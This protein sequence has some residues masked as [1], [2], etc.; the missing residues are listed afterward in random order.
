MRN[1]AYLVLLLVG[2]LIAL[3]DGQVIARNASACL[4]GAYDDPRHERQ[5]VGLVVALFHLTMLGL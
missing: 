1:D 5:A 2:L 3:A 4:H